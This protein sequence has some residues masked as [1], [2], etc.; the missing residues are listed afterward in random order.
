MVVYV[1]P[2]KTEVITFIS[3][4]LDDDLI[5]FHYT[6]NNTDFLCP[7]CRAKVE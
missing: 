5:D 7:R 6:V 4:D 2:E 1:M 3:V